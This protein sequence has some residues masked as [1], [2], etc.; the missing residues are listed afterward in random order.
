MIEQDVREDLKIGMPKTEVVEIFGDVD[1]TQSV[2][3]YD[4][5]LPEAE[6]KYMLEIT[7]D[8]AGLKDFKRQR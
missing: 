7:F 2:L 4:L 1:T 3:I 5:S 6:E 8:D